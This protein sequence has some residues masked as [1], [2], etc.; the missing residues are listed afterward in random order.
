MRRTPLFL[1]LL[2]ASIMVGYLTWRLK[3]PL[4]KLN[5][6]ILHETGAETMEFIFVGDSGS[7]LPDQYKLADALERY[8]LTHPLRAVFLLGDNFYPIGVQSVDDPQWQSKFHDPY[9]K[10]C[11]GQIPFYPILGN[12]DYKGHPAAQIA[13]TQKHTQWRMPHRFYSIQFGDLAKIIALDTNIADICGLAE[14]CVLD[15]LRTE[16]A[17][18]SIPF[19]IVIG[20][21]PILSSSGKYGA[22]VLGRVLRSFMCRA[23]ATYIAGHSHH[24]EHRYDADCALDLFISGGGGASLYETRKDDPGTRFVQSNHGFLRARI[25]KAGRAFTFFDSDL[26]ELYSFT[27]R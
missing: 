4:R 11:L 20:H 3:A 8:C 26:K 15:F 19:R 18:E 5:P 7:G 17:D 22:T 9:N 27:D 10:P 14:H 12:H 1:L 13:Y 24:L 16:L 25:S 6:N 23:G 21:H 2:F